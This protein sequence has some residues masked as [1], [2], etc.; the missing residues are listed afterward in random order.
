MP[1]ENPFW[2]AINRLSNLAAVISIV[3][4]AIQFATKLDIIRGSGTRT[5]T[6]GVVAAV[7]GLAGLG[8]VGYGIYYRRSVKKA[9]LPGRGRNS[10]WFILGGAGLLF[11]TSF[12]LIWI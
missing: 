5:L 2:T 8:L 12:A 9:F 6:V 11:A 3:I 7:L 1:S 10:T 4:A